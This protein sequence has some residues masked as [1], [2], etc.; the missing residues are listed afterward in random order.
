MSFITKYF[1]INPLV[2]DLSNN[3][4]NL[5]FLVRTSLSALITIRDY[6]HLL[7]RVNEMKAELAF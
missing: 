5:E 3:K 1:N 6:Y 4:L 7:K 2:I